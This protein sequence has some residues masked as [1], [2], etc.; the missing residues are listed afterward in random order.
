E[1]VGKDPRVRRFDGAALVLDLKA[2]LERVGL[3]PPGARDHESMELE[4]LALPGV[5][6]RHHFV[7]VLVVFGSFAQRR[8]QQ[9]RKR[10]HQHDTGKP[11]TFAYEPTIRG[12]NREARP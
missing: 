6:A 11:T 3:L 5:R 9:P 10:Q 12:M 7:N 2:I 8:P 1:R 4:T